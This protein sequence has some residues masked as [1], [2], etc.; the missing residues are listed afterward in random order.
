MKTVKS[1]RNKSNRLFVYILPLRNENFESPPLK[2]D[3]F[4]LYPTFKE[5]KL[6][7]SCQALMQAWVYILPL[8]N[9]NQERLYKS[10][11]SQNIWFISY[12]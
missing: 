2:D 8:R 12:L 7:H 4:C 11:N 9:E 6:W 3:S 5:W 1:K 10:C